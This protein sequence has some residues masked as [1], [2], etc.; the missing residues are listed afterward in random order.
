MGFLHQGPDSRS[1]HLTLS[2]SCQITN[3]QSSARWI[4]HIPHIQSYQLHPLP[5]PRAQVQ[6]Q[7][8]KVVHHSS[9]N[10][11]QT[12]GTRLSRRQVKRVPP[13]ISS[14]LSDQNNSSRRKRRRG[15]VRN[16]IL[17]TKTRLPSPSR[18]AKTLG[19]QRILH[20]VVN[21]HP[22]SRLGLCPVRKRIRW[23]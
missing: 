14:P 16:K 17:T 20:P 19:R 15:S 1:S 22:K 12:L 5:P 23:M 4:P 6:T 7:T 3:R 13:S 10:L 9:R 8:S 21:S 18:N 2:L 11:W